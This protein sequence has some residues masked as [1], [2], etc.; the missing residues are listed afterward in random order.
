VKV[1]FITH[2][3][4]LYGANRSLLLLIQGLS[5][6]HGIR[7]HVIAPKRG[8]FTELLEARGIPVAI[9]PFHWWM[10]LTIDY[11]RPLDIITSGQRRRQAI[12][13]AIGNAWLMK[14][15]L[16]VLKR[17]K[18]DLVHTNS[19]VIPVGALAARF[20]GLPHVWHWREFG[21]LDYELAPDWGW[22]LHRRVFDRSDAIIAVSATVQKHV[23]ARTGCSSKMIWDPG[24]S[25]ADLES[26]RSIRQG[27]GRNRQKFVFVLL[28]VLH[29]AKS[30]T[31]AILAI[32]IVVKRYPHCCLL[33]V[34]DGIDWELK[35]LVEKLGIGDHVLFSGFQADPFQVLLEADA[36]LT[37]SKNEAFGRTAVEAMAACLPV[38]GFDN[39][40]TG[41]LIRDG[42]T[43]LLYRQDHLELAECMMRLLDSP[44]WAKEMGMN[45]WDAVRAN[46]TSE[47]HAEAVGD[48]FRNISGMSR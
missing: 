48:V 2:T 3:S 30:Q 36:L 35:G 4:T 21:D 18:I 26:Y 24:A 22:Y 6:A 37:C 45:G 15:I 10:G 12:A 17:W 11:S 39:A 42:L 38:V 28:G 41:E 9:I 34:G 8:P 47:A 29:P 23:L 27:Q 19:S 5:G 32:E 25:I 16:E 20:A 14:R 7:P 46:L 40:G 33:I 13:R 44:G 1:A 31:D 43:G